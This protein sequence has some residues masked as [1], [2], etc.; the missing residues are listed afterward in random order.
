MSNEKFIIIGLSESDLVEMMENG[1]TKEKCYV[2]KRSEYDKGVVI[3]ENGDAFAG[4]IKI[5]NL[6]VEV[7]DEQTH[8]YPLC[9]ECLNLLTYISKMASGNLLQKLQQSSFSNN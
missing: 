1:E 9:K 4:R 5:I 2:C 8:F 7:S 3:D 6:P